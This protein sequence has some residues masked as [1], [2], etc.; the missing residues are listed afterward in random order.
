MEVKLTGEEYKELVSKYD[1]LCELIADSL[2]YYNFSEAH[3]DTVYKFSI[4]ANRLDNKLIEMI[5]KR[6]KRGC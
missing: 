1:D 5:E 3:V 2:E 6:K 4:V